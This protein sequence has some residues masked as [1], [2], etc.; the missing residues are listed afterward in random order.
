[1]T[2]YPGWG[3]WSFQPVVIIALL[4]AGVLYAR[5][6]RRAACALVDLGAQRRPLG[7]V[8]RRAAD[9]RGGAALAA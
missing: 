8:R 2:H 7:P 3:S 9:D 6:Y 4:A 5:M 1:M